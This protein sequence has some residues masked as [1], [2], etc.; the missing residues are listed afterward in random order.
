MLMQF[1]MVSLE[2]KLFLPQ[3]N[4]FKI[5]DRTDVDVTVVKLKIKFG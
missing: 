4:K 2:K 3:Y 5:W 1:I